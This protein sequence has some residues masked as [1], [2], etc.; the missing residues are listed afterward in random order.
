[1]ACRVVDTRR[2]I[3]LL[4]SMVDSERPPCS[5]VPNEKLMGNRTFA[6]VWNSYES[7]SIRRESDVRALFRTS[8][9][10]ESKMG[11]WNLGWRG[12]ND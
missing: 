8:R 11:P 5:Y 9:Q 6:R 10:S 4:G 3:W 7:I 12:S 1:M 2:S